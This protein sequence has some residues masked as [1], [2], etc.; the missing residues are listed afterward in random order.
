MKKI[1]L[2]RGMFA[3]VDDEDY[4]KV[5]DFK[6]Q[7]HRGHGDTYYAVSKKPNVAMHRF[8]LEVADIKIEVDHADRNGLNNRRNNISKCTRSFNMLQRK[9]FTSNHHK[10]QSMFK[11]VSRRP[12]YLWWNAYLRLDNKSYFCGAFVSEEAAARARDVK[13]IELLGVARACVGSILNF[14]DLWK[15]R[16]F[17]GAEV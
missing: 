1:Q 5:K 4:N 14:P 11:G 9:K 13:V 15:P 3:I 8:L 6:W 12:G 2:T 17:G 10:P 16:K 7:A